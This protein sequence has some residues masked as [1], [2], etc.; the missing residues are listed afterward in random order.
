[1]LPGVK[2]SWREVKFLIGLYLG[3]SA[4]GS[5]FGAAGSVV[6]ILLWIYYS[7]QIVLFGAE[8]TQAVVKP[9]GSKQSR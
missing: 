3:H 4:V 7:S 1:M 2:L 9:L 8:V 6:I 5:S